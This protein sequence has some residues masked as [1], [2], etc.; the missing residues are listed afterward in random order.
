M[1]PRGSRL[2]PWIKWEEIKVIGHLVLSSRYYH[3]ASTMMFCFTPDPT[4]EGSE[5]MSPNKTSPLYVVEYRYFVVAMES[6]LIQR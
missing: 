2:R 6:Q 5:T 1:M 4:S 3:V